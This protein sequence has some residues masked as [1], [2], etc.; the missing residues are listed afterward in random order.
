MRPTPACHLGGN[1]GR[2]SGRG[3]ARRR[4]RGHV[5]PL[6]DAPT[7][8]SRTPRTW[9]N[10]SDPSPTLKTTIANQSLSLPLPT[11]GAP[12]S[13]V[14]VDLAAGTVSGYPG[15]PSASGLI[16]IQCIPHV[17]LAVNGQPLSFSG[18]PGD[19]TLTYTPAAADGGSLTRAGSSQTIDFSG[20]SAGGLSINPGA[21]NDTVTTIGTAGVDVINGTTKA[22]T[23]TV[24]VN[25]LLALS[26][27]TPGTEV[28]GIAAGDE[29]NTINVTAFNGLNQVV[30][31]DGAA[32]GSKKHIQTY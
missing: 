22:P 6:D 10:V 18:T 25:S 24:Q 2:R 23:S 4:V 8:S 15:I 30:T 9:R 1:A 14:A 5:H 16:G 19:D 12:G 11:F 28:V 3:H 26:L 7:A 31:V 29:A 17:S 20:V 13:P 21:G 27:A 32:S